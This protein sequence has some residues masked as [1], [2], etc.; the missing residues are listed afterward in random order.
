MALA[1]VV[2]IECEGKLPGA[3][4][5]FCPGMLWGREDQLCGDDTERATYK[6]R[7]SKMRAE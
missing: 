5:L 6:G 7:W 1:E 4:A 2:Q 3:P